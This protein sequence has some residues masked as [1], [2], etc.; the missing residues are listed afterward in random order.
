[1]SVALQARTAESEK[2]ATK[3]RDEL[4]QLQKQLFR[5]QEL[6]Q[7]GALGA[8]REL[9]EQLDE[10]QHKVMERDD[11]LMTLKKR[12]DAE[13]RGT[14]ERCAMLEK[15]LSEKSSELTRAVND[16]FNAS[17]ISKQL[18]QHI[19]MLELRLK[20][21]IQIAKVRD[22]LDGLRSQQ[23]RC[24]SPGRPSPQDERQ[25]IRPDLS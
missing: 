12:G 15:R 3:K 21:A 10:L 25:G 18:Q 6:L 24:A 23:V 22:P 13:R 11:A 17:S 7:A 9:R 2:A 8:E 20:K 4:E 14:T 16:N 5:D 1:M 19:A